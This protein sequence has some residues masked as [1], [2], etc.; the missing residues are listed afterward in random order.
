MDELSCRIE[1]DTHVKGRRVVRLDAVICDVHAGVVLGSTAPLA[2]ST[3]Q[4]VCDAQ[5]GQFTAI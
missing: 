1:V 3:V 5:F 4:D 2:L